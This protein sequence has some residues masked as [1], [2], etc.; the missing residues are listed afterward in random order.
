MAESSQPPVFCDTQHV[1]PA[2]AGVGAGVGVG[3]VA[4]QV[5]HPYCSMALT[6]P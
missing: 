2:V 6:Q 1:E 5:S 4:E 3:V